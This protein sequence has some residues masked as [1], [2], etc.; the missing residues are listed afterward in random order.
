MKLSLAM[1]LE[2]IKVIGNGGG[3]GISDPSQIPDLSL[4]YKPGILADG[5]GQNQAVGWYSNFPTNTKGFLLGDNFTE[6]MVINGIT[7]WNQN[8][9]IKRYMSYEFGTADTDIQPFALR[10]IFTN[11]CLV[12]IPDD[13]AVASIWY[14][15]Q[16]VS[17]PDKWALCRYNF[18]AG[19]TFNFQMRPQQ[20]GGTILSPAHTPLISGDIAMLVS[21]FDYNTKELKMTV[22][23]VTSSAIVS[24]YDAG[25]TGMNFTQL[26]TQTGNPSVNCL[27]NITYNRILTNEELNNLGA[28]LT[29]WRGQN[30]WTDL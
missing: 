2:V 30:V 27:D 6:T 8:H 21:S 7:M 10:G 24:D 9:P 11:V 14:N 13:T 18:T 26:Q 22:R 17:E 1:G 28:L 23:G 19:K 3:G 16:V 4:Y 5:G 29:V 15:N 20:T 25:V 12:H